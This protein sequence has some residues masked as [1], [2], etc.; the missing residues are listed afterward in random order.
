V[1][2]RR[3]RSRLERVGALVPRVLSDLGLE[4]SARVVRIAERWPEL[5]GPALGAEL[6][7]RGRPTAWRAG[8]LEVTVDSPASAQSLMLHK[9]ALLEALRAAL[10]ESAPRDLRLRVG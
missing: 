1:R 9:P 2:P 7:R 8:T 6:A 4:D 3:P 5:A 10:G